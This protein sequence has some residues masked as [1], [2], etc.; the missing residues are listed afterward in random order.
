[1]QPEE[2]LELMRSAPR[3]YETVRAALRYRGD[4]VAIKAARQRYLASE[5][6]KFETR[7][8][9]PPSGEED[10]HSEPDG[11][12]GW[13]CRV[14]YAG[15]NPVGGGGGRFRRRDARPRVGRRGR[16]P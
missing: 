11:P 6:F 16:G 14:W 9:P 12:F 10:V 5:L 4:G 2:V 7:G 3:R 1:M 13:S 8:A 15:V